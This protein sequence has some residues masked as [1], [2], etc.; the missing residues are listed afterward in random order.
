MQFRGKNLTLAMTFLL[1][2]TFSTTTEV[3]G[4]AS[5][6]LSGNINEVLAQHKITRLGAGERLEDPQ[7]SRNNSFTY[8]SVLVQP[9]GDDYVIITDQ[10]NPACDA[11]LEKLANLHHGRII[12]CDD[13]RLLPTDVKIRAGIVNALR[14]AK[15]KYV[16][17]APRLESFNENVVL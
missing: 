11:A 7:K 5:D 2:F 3:F 16:A 14:E 10:V 12:H 6:S 13:F 4:Q 8:S 9:P 1:L 15:P 17:I